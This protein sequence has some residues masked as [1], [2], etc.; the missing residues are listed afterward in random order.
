MAENFFS[1][2]TVTI[3]A[4]GTVTWSWTGTE[5][6]NVTGSFGASETKKGIT[7]SATFPAAGTYEYA[8][9]IHEAS[10]MR[11]TVIVE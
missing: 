7:F 10:G 6:H 8:C 3:A 4:G 9:T 2:R 5:I 11:G 1:P